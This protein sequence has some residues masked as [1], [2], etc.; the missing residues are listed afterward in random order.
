MIIIV[1][2]VVMIVIIMIIIVVRPIS[3]YTKTL[4]FGGFDSNVILTLRGG[5][6]MSTEISPKDL[7]RASLVGRLLVCYIY[8][9]IYIHV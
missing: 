2:V 1:R 4:D 6:L 8:I 3:V 9:Y 5:T 7:S